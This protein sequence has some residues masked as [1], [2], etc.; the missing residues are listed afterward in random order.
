[1]SLAANAMSLVPAQFHVSDSA[2]GKSDL[3]RSFQFPPPAN[4]IDLLQI[5]QIPDARSDRYDLNRLDLADNVKFHTDSLPEAGNANKLS[6]GH[7]P[8]FIIASGLGS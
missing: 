1:M 7:G 2:V 8:P 5:S 6:C 4:A 3:S